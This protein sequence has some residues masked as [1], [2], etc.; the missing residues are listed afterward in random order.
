M[1]WA[2]QKSL[3]KRYFFNLLFCSSAYLYNTKSLG[4]YCTVPCVLPRSFYLFGGFVDFWVLG[5]LGE[6][7]MGVDEGR[8]EPNSSKPKK[9][10]VQDVLIFWFFRF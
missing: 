7:W 10:F 4:V 9:Q 5:I 8:E 2:H 1:K 6:F 3:N